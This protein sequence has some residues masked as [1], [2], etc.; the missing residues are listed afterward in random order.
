MSKKEQFI[1][2]STHLLKLWEAYLLKEIKE[3]DF[4]VIESELRSKLCQIQR[5]M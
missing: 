3:E 4:I 2:V 1:Q 5:E